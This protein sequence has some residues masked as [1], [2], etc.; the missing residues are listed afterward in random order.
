MFHHPFPLKPAKRIGDQNQTNFDKG[1]N[2][3][4]LNLVTISNWTIEFKI[5]SLPSSKQE[6]QFCNAFTSAVFHSI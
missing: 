6:H 4:L 1:R 2:K 3:K 5:V